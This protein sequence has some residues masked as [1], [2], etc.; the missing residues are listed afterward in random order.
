[1][2]DGYFRRGLIFD[3]CNK[4]TDE[5]RDINLIH[6][7]TTDSALSTLLNLAIEGLLRLHL[8]KKFT[9]GENPT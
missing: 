9:I 1:M 7:L 2:S 6:K 8:N 5:N 4:F 3:F